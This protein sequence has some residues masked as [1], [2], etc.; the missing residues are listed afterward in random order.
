MVGNT[1]N[2]GNICVCVVQKWFWFWFVFLMM[3]FWWGNSTNWIKQLSFWWS[4]L[5]GGVLGDLFI[6]DIMIHIYRRYFM[7][8]SEWGC[9]LKRS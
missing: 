9:R 7:H 3:K 4:V 1:Q 8:F 5:L 6:Y 2:M